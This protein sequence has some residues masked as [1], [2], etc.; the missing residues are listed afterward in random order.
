MF[1]FNRRKTLPA[2]PE[3]EICAPCDGM[4]FPLESSADAVFAAKTLGEGFF[5]QPSDT[6]I[7]AP[8]SGT[9]SALFPTKHA[10]GIQSEEG[11][12]VLL[13]IG[14]DTVYAKGLPIESDVRIHERIRRGE[15]H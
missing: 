7:Y 5:I 8:L 13:H 9:I 15:H 10:I 14:I 11:I 12:E 3:I 1:H 4:L 2:S 6:L